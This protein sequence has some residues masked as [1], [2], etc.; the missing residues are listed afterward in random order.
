MLVGKLQLQDL[1]TYNHLHVENCKAYA[2]TNFLELQVFKF[3][4]AET[5]IKYMEFERAILQLTIYSIVIRYYGMMPNYYYHTTSSAIQN[6]FHSR[7][8]QIAQSECKNQLST[9]NYAFCGL[10]FHNLGSRSHYSDLIDCILTISKYG[11][12]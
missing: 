6:Y 3:L 10:L 4:T 9:R 5:D 1:L 2:K 12:L 8:K 7:I 11:F